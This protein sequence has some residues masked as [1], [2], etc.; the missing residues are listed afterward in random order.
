VEPPTSNN[1]PISREPGEAVVAVLAGGMATRLG[2]AKA[3][4]ML[5]GR[6]LIEYPLQAAA[7]A[8][9]ASIV[10]AKAASPLP[11]I[12]SE[13][14]IE[15]D[16]PSHPLIGIVTALRHAGGRTVV[17]LACDLPLIGPDLLRRLATG[18]ERLVV[19][20][21]DGRLQPLAARY[22]P[23]LLPTLE[24]DLED[25]RRDS[26]SM[27]ELV[28]RLDPRIVGEQ[29]IARFGNPERMFTNVNEPGDLEL[30]AD[31]LDTT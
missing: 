30:A 14:V 20:S 6:P 15:P 18:P 5:A 10:V 9:L 23:E 17:V 4:L 24:A 11:P 21:I 16:R 29:E 28:R 12:T 26:I 27:Q 3:S 2:G 31:L 7:E 25:S 1:R 19:P 8:G 13:I 22:D